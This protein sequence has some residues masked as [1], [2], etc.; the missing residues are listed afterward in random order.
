MLTQITLDT[1]VAVGDYNGMVKMMIIMLV[2]LVVQSVFQYIHTYFSGWLGQQVI[3]DIRMKLYEHLIS[4][5]LRFFDKTPIGRL[6]TRTISDVETL[7]DVFSE[8]LA[9]MISDL[10][11][12][13]FILAFMFYQDWRL[14]LIS[15]STIP[16]L[17]ISTYVFKEKIKVAFGDVP[18]LLPILTLLFRNISLE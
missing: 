15:L 6:V 8:G 11:Q 4:L 5:R 10:L 9:A 13:I 12:L 14:S 3:R 7:S 1:D 2:M 16:L 17:L 18:M